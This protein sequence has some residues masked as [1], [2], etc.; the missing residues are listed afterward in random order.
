M[1]RNENFK[2]ANGVE[3][4]KVGYGT[5]QIRDREECI[6][7]TIW[8]LKA[9]YRHIDTAA[10]YGNIRQFRNGLFRFIFNSCSKTM[11]R[12]KW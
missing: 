11:G 1:V 6:N 8:A 2:L 9:G 5:W 10:A 3:I 12:Y 4:P 7:G